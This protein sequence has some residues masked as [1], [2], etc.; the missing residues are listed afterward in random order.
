MLP[1]LS[2]NN[3]DFINIQFGR[4]GND[5][6]YWSS[7]EILE[8][9]KN[10]ES[11]HRINIRTIKEIDNYSDIESLAALINCLDLIITIDNSNAHLAGALGKRTWVMLV[12]NPI[13][14]WGLYGEKSLWYPNSKLFR[15]EKI[16]DWSN[17]INNINADIR[18]LIEN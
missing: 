9:L 4:P 12:K 13:W 2:N 15:Q 10:I 16:G 6:K 1:F 7:K 11:T 8:D 14:S 5:I 17:V 18:K 3:C